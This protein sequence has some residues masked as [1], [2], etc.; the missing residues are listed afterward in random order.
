MRK[1]FYLRG[2]LAFCFILFSAAVR[3]TP[4]DTLV[5]ISNPV[6][7]TVFAGFTAHFTVSAIDTPSN[8]AKT[9]DWQFSNDGTTWSDYSISDPVTDTSSTISFVVNIGSP[10]GTTWYRC[11][12]V[13]DNGNDTSAAAELV[14][15]AGHAPIITSNPH[16]TTVCVSGSAG[17]SV[18]AIDTPGTHVL[19]YTW[20]ESP[21]GSIWDT[22]ATADIDTA[23]LSGLGTNSLTMAS[24]YLLLHDGYMYEVVVGTDSG[25]AVST[26]ATLHIDLP[27]AGTITGPSAVCQGSTITLSSDIAG[28]I[29]SNTHHAID[30]V[31]ASGDVYGIAPGT[32][33]VTYAL[34]N[35]CGPVFSAA[36]IT[37]DTV[38]TGMPISGPT[39]T[40]IGRVID[41][42]D[43]V[44][45]GVWSSSGVYA[46]VNPSGMVDGVSSGFEII[47]YTLSNACNTDDE[48][49]GVEVDAVINPGTISGPS[50]VC[51][52]SWV[53]F[54]ST[55]EEGT[56]LTS[57][58]AIAIVDGDGNVTGVSDGV[59][60][61]SYYYMNACGVSAATDT[62]IVS[63]PAS[64]IVGLDSVGVG[65]TRLLT[66]SSAGG[67]WASAD[68][69]IATVGSAT[70][71]V[72]GVASG[73]VVI[74][75]TVTNSC[76]TST[77]SVIMQVGVT[78]AGVI[79]GADTVCRDFTITLTN[80]LSG[81]FWTSKYDTV[82]TVDSFTG[83]V[84][85]VGQGID[86]VYYTYSGGFGA[87]SVKA[88]VFVD[89][90]PVDSIARPS[91]FA[92]GG[93]YTLVGYVFSRQ[94]VVLDSV[95]HPDSIT[96]GVY[97]DSSIWVQT[98]GTWTSSN[99]SVAIFIS[100]S[101]SG[102]IV[103]HGHGTATITYTA[104]NRC[105]TTDTTFVIDIPSSTVSG[106]NEITGGVSVLNVYPNPSTGD[107]TIN[108]ASDLT[109]QAVVTVTNIV[110]EKVKEFTIATNQPTELSLDQPDGVYFISTVTSTGKYSAKV[111][112][113]R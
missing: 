7:D 58:S 64:E 21:D 110:G 13:N 45:G 12:V 53:S 107:F 98:P 34:T 10:A 109:E 81:G 112:I 49:Y 3:A 6:N 57:S 63:A 47:H 96:R 38:L 104:A 4:V 5:I 65:F 44:P 36:Y 56:W 85:G 90:P 69:S 78:S 101:S 76:G 103:I 61:I 55:G 62:L 29:W 99:P 8:L 32:D 22:V 2:L 100:G 94:V 27:V 24:G 37:V 77:A 43:P 95:R 25:M 46:Y 18:A 33:T 35:A 111:T 91:I 16:D 39:S 20:F 11:V 105:G 73:S 41:L 106:V 19:Q 66:D 88:S 89:Q 26:A 17:F 74:S 79:H 92:Y 93:S 67:T 68:N 87:S 84:T 60:I 23:D 40:C 80:T 86:S 51:A 70:G 83:V 113:T 50:T 31:D 52:G 30:T 71:V 72:T 97:V 75:Y 82:A 14:V 59:A 42:T 108:M 1:S 48:T 15:L 102:I 28:G 9:Y 54:T